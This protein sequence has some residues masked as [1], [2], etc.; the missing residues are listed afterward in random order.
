MVTT[1]YKEA[2]GT[3]SSRPHLAVMSRSWS[4]HLCWERGRRECHFLGICVCVFMCLHTPV[5]TSAQVPEYVCVGATGSQRSTSDVMPQLLPNLLLETGPPL[6]R[7]WG[8][9]VGYA[10]WPVSPRNPPVSAFLFLR[11]QEGTPCLAFYI[12]PENHLRS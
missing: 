7:T 5:N 10:G 2:M 3:H 11:S 6:T 9:L 4:M 8:S 12:C 1:C